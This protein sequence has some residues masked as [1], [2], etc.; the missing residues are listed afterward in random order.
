MG[1]NFVDLPM[2]LLMPPSVDNV[3]EIS[4][5]TIPSVTKVEIKHFL[6]SMYGFEV[7]KVRTLNMQGKR[8]RRGSRVVARPNYKKAY[9]T[10]KKPLTDFYHTL[11]A[12]RERKN[13]S[14]S[15]KSTTWQENDMKYHLHESEE[16]RFKLEKQLSQRRSRDL[17]SIG[18]L[19]SPNSFQ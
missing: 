6:E 4:F 12:G 17:L 13:T 2:K 3:K 14:Q 9:V 8:K 7:E 19:G 5:K 10:L 1:C 11:A 18:T 15:P 16:A